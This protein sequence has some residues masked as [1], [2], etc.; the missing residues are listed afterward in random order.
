MSKSIFPTWLPRLVTPASVDQG[1][2][3][4]GN[5]GDDDGGL[6]AGPF[7]SINARWAEHVTAAGPAGGGTVTAQTA[8]VPT[9]SIYVLQ[10]WSLFHNDN[11]AAR[12]IALTLY[13]GTVGVVQ[14]YNA[15]LALN[16]YAYDWGQWVLTAGD[17][18]RAVG[19]GFTEAKV[20]TL[21]VW[22]YQVTL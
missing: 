15:A 3:L 5:R 13:T 20:L 2:D 9:G 10:G 14:Y 22:G 7:G 11:V 6:F 12:A 4:H 17:R 16:T 18:L 21:D 8:V 19:I 1:L